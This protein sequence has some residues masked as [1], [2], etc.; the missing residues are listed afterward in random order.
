MYKN[1]YAMSAHP[2]DDAR[3]PPPARVVHARGAVTPE[4]LSPASDVP[5]TDPDPREPALDTGAAALDDSTAA[6]P[7]DDGFAVFGLSEP[8]MRALED[9]GY[10]APT[11]IQRA[12]ISRMLAGQDVIAQAQTGTGKTAAY[13]IPI[14]ERVNPARRETQALVL[15]PTR[16]LAVQVAEALHQLGRH[17]HVRVLPVYGGQPIERQLRGLREGAHVVAGTPGRILDHLRR[18]TL[19]L[20]NVRLAVLDDADEMLDMGFLEDVEAILAELPGLAV[21]GAGLNPLPS[22]PPLEEGTEALPLGEL[23]Q[24][25]GPVPGRSA[26]EGSARDSAG[27][28]ATGQAATG[29]AATGQGATKDSAVQLGLFSATMPAPVERLARQFMRDAERISIAPEQVTVPQIAQVAYEVAGMDKLDALSRVLDVEAPGSAMVFCATRRMVDEVSERLAARGYRAAALHGD[30]GQGERERVLRRFRDG[31]VEV[32]VA[33]DVAARGLDISGVTH[34]VNFDIP[35]DPEAYVHRIGRTGRAGRAGDAITL[36]TSRDYRALR[37]IEQALRVRITRK[38]LPSLAD[39][40]T[41]R[42]EAAKASVASTIQAGELD[43][44]LTLAGELGDEFDPVEVAA[45]ALR[46]WDVARAAGA[47]E[48]VTLVGAQKAAEQEEAASRARSERDTRRLEQ[49]AAREAAAEFEADGQ[50]PEAGM[51]RLLVAS[52]RFDGLRPQDLVGA[53]AN[54]AGIPGRAVGAIDIYDRFSFVEVPEADADRVVEALTHATIRGRQVGARRA[55]PDAP[56]PRTPRTRRGAAGPRQVGGGGY[57]S[58]ARGGYQ[59][60]VDGPAR[61]ERGAE[62]PARYAGEARQARERPTRARGTSEEY[63]R[64][65]PAATDEATSRTRRGARATPALSARVR[66]RPRE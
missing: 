49:R 21:G 32:L 5:G 33:T 18:G 46:L 28:G 64:G 51:A 36:V 6:E 27:E 63:E 26:G 61:H 38:R 3:Q 39:V 9:L 17:K 1:A 13:G 2:N 7:L 41:R 14:V 54:E 45:A 50:A 37:I 34:V 53:I 44:Y 25:R 12:T 10:E 58:G 30:M 66:R 20:V 65:Q 4:P 23:P 48:G 31:Q 59:R 42:R 22:P 11:P 47:G 29:Q 56:P 57:G 15:A 8:V 19:S 40:A 60:R 55:G 62:R 43:G 16:E 52:G 24:A 35:W